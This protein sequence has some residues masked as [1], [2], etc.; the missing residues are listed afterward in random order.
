MLAQATHIVGGFISYRFLSDSTYEVKLTIYRDCNSSTP[1]D[2]TPGA[3]TNA[4][5]GL[6]NENTG[7]IYN[8][9]GLVDP[10]INTIQPPID[11]PCLQIPPGVCVEEGVYTY[12]ITLPSATEGFT[13]VYERCCRNG[14]ITNVFD[15]G[16]QGAVYSAYIPPTNTFHNSSPVFTNLPPTFICVNSPLILN[17]SATDADGDVL[18]YSLCTPFT[19][20][21]TASPAPN[22]PV[23]PPF[24]NITWQTPY[25]TAD[26]LGGVPLT[27]DNNTGVLTGT[28]NAQGQFVV[29][30]CVSEYRN[31][32]LIGTYLRDGQFNVTQCNIPV[33]GIPSTD[34]NPSTQIGTYIINCSNLHVQFQNTSYNP[35]PANVPMTFNWDFGVNGINSDTS[36]V[37]VPFY[38]YP[39]T[40]TYFVRLI[41]IK[42]TG[43]AA[44]IDTTYAYVYIY[45]THHSDFATANVCQGVT[46]NFTDQSV[47]SIGNI[48]QWNWNFG[49]GYTSTLT[50]PS[51]LYS[52][53]GTYN[54][55]LVGGNDLGCKDT[56]TKIIIIFPTPAADFSY[57]QTCV[58]TVVN[59]TDNTNGSV[60]SY[61]W[62]L[63]NGNNS[64][65]QNPSTTY[66]AT[67]DYD[68][69]L[70]AGL[71]G[72]M[73]T[74][75]KTITV[76][77]VPVVANNDTGICP[78]QSVQLTAS[79][80][81]IYTWSPSIG[82]NDSTLANPV[83]T[84][85]FS[86]TYSIVAVNQFQCSAND[87]VTISVFPLPNV[88]AS[89]D[90]SVCLS[91]ANFRDSVQLKATGAVNYQWG[92][93][94]SLSSAFVPNPIARP[95]SN[96]T[97][98]V[99]GTDANGCSAFD[100]VTVF[101]LDPTI[102]IILD[103]SK[104]VCLFDTVY[105][106]VTS[107]GAS[108]YVWT[109]MQFL[110][111]AGSYSPGFF[112]PNSTT[113]TLTV[114]NYCY[115]KSD[116]VLI[117][118]LQPPV[119]SFTHPDSLCINDTLQIAV[120]GAQTYQWNFD[121]TLSALNISNPYAYPTSSQ[122]YY[123][124]AVD[125]NGCKNSDSTF[126]NVVPLPYVNAGND[127]LI[128]RDTKAFLDG[129]TDASK[130]YWSPVTFLSNSKSLQTWAAIT[131]PQ[132]YVLFAQN[133]FGC[134]NNDTIFIS[135]E[136]NNIL[137]VPTAFSPNG[138]GVN[139][140]FRIIRYLNIYKL[141]EF[142]VWNR[143]GEK[144][145][146]TTDINEGWDGTFGNH[147]QPMS[148]YVWQVVAE[149]KDSEDIVRKGN[150][151]LVR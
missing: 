55:T 146:S 25:S 50:S 48:N 141:K 100:S 142:S 41:A 89:P 135:I 82:L 86:T 120:S 107:Q 63:G 1:F 44:C 103:A 53:Y 10:V 149:T 118:V 147:A 106:N 60:T 36:N 35:P 140:V 66:N 15:P 47:S 145:F 59:F 117:V 71:N 23:G 24:S 54:V 78:G 20:G 64:P 12:N 112:P 58:N 85:T 62:S 3:T 21:S 67:G 99:L 73:D 125:V 102:N 43:S 40:G 16:T 81:T 87:V 76:H 39:D 130:Y 61:A 92:P 75:A 105:A 17:Y 28:P 96:T 94:I 31:G 65:Q 45:P 101:V 116:S 84:P 74:V 119:L 97:Y 70:I 148:A 8:T 131:K 129:S 111:N 123:V 93:S 18:T 109:P 139:D 90:T 29:G 91:G 114:S 7:N 14:T 83:A 121:N 56:V 34:I 69:V 95:I 151:T 5:L 37:P 108:N 13:L 104:N 98:L 126:V 88:L 136:T 22:P 52:T 110:L 144:V 2:G 122:Y 19:G 9:F 68:V 124:S 137:L 80:G 11:N 115:S 79:G 133:D 51:H 6:F 77:P 46:A 132:S 113:Y 150:V 32:Q 138:D 26:L 38:D 57:G 49:D 33:A 128:W 127:T 134:V 27:I 42:G 30:V 4:I 143:W 72:C